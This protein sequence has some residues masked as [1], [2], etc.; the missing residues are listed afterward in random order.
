MD[1]IALDVVIGIVFVYLLYSLLASIIQEISAHIFDLRAKMLKRGIKRMLE[2][3]SKNTVFVNQFYNHPSI[4]YLAEKRLLYDKPSYMSASSFSQTLIYLLRG[5]HW[6]RASD[7]SLEIENR[8]GSGLSAYKNAPTNAIL[9]NGQL[10]DDIPYD[11]L[12]HLNN[13]FQDANG[14]LTK[15]KEN[16]EK[17]YDDTMERV[18]GWYKRQT[19]VYLLVI[20]LIISI[21]GN[22][23]TV[24]IYHVLSTDNVAREQMVKMAIEQRESY[25]TLVDRYRQ[26]N[27]TD[28][29]IEKLNLMNDNAFKTTYQLVFQDAKNAQSILGTGWRSEKALKTLDSLKHLLDVSKQKLATLKLGISA[30][31]KA[32]AE[33]LD[34]QIK[35]YSEQID[36]TKTF[37]WDKFDGVISILGWFLTAIALSFGAPFWFDLLNKLIN[38][39]AAGKK[40]VDSQKT[41][42]LGQTNTSMPLGQEKIKV[43]AAG[44]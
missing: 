4:K 41:E 7:P 35:K 40:P 26:T 20:G 31:A 14:D 6:N 42:N 1:N 33:K 18:T 37:S 32:K 25:A 12:I 36:G 8:I 13:L 21:I 28:S 24:K 38:I 11:T 16:L 3:G 22:V 43:T 34:Q 15:F 39:R 19:Q 27:P 23:D 44:G 30:A 5:D 17:W 10:P 29:M 2:D 9:P